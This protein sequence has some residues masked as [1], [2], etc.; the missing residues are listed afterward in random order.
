MKVLLAPWHFIW[1]TPNGALAMTALF[2]IAF[3]GSFFV[4]PGPGLVLG[5]P[6]LGF[7]AR[8]K[9]LERERQRA[10]GTGKDA[11]RKP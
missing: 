11:A 5:L 8:Y 9:L 4:L 6:A 1:E 7:S 3:L 2:L 10:A